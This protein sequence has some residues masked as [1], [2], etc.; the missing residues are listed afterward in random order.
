MFF[1]SDCLFPFIVTTLFSMINFVLRQILDSS[2]SFNSSKHIV[3]ISSILV[4]PSLRIDMH[5]FIID[6]KCKKM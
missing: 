1:S 3:C 4:V 5:G 6:V 2:F